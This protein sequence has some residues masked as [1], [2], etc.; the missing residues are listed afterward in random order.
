MA[1]LPTEL[2]PIPE[3]APKRRSP[4]PFVVGI[5]AVLALVAGVVV[6]AS[7]GE[8][9]GEVA[10]IDLLGAAPDAAR[11]AGRAHMTITASMEGDGLTLDVNAEGVEDFASGE[12]AMTMMLMGVDIEMRVVDGFLYQRL[13]AMARPPGIDTEWIGVP[14]PAQQA[15]LSADPMSSL[16]GGAAMLD[17]LRGMGN[18]ITELG[19]DE[20]DGVE[21]TGYAVTIDLTRAIENIPEGAGRDD[22]EIGLDAMRAMGMDSWPM[23]IWLDGDGLPVRMQVDLELPVGTMAMQIDYSDFGT[24]EPIEA[25]PAEDVHLFDS[26]AEMQEV[27]GGGAPAMGADLELSNY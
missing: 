16:Q 11:E 21:V 1:D 3:P 12:M 19:R 6:V 9:E 23:K 26:L 13:P 7:D 20:I 2:E 27:L 14:T 18:D 8:D 25:P 5:I 10:A 4:L 24:D 22:A 15:G 17:G